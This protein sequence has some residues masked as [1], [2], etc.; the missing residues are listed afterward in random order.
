MHVKLPESMAAICDENFS[1]R[2]AP[3]MNEVTVIYLVDEQKIEILIK[4]PADYPLHGIE[5][6]EVQ[7]IAHAI[8][9]NRWRSWL[10]AAQQVINSQ[11]N[12]TPTQPWNR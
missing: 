3:A 12:A 2:V 1:L 8:P 9:E 10:F 5:V 7:R 4:L 6:R 11:V